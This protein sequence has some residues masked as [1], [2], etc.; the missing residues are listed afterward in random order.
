MVEHAT[1][2]DDPAARPPVSAPAQERAP[3]QLREATLIGVRWVALGRLGSEVFAFVSAVV[4]AHL[5]SPAEFGRAAVP[6]A[7]VPLAVILTFE[8]FA[9]ALVQRP[10]VKDVDRQ[11][12]V[13]LSVVSGLVLSLA[14]L[15]FA[16]TVAASV[17]SARSAHLL[18]LASPL[19]VIASVGAVPRATL[20]RKLDFR[21]VS[22]VEV[23]SIAVGASASIGLAV[24]GHDAEALIGGALIGTGASSL[25]FV[26]LVPLPTG[27]PSVHSIREIARFG[28]PASIA[29]LIGVA[30]T[31][32]SYVILAARAGA[33]QT[34]L[35][36]RAF[37]LGV[38]YQEKVSG[39]MLRVAFPVYS[40]AKDTA[41][42][43]RV[44]ERATRV[45]ATVILPMLTLLIAL[46]PLLIPWLLGSA[47]VAAVRPT[48]ILAL[49][50][51]AS[52]LLTGYPQVMLGMGRPQMLL[53]F[54]IA[55]LAVY[56]TVVSIAAGHG[57][58]TVCVCVVVVQFA[59]LWAVY[60][61]LF[62][63][64]LGVPIRRL[65]TDV[66]PAATG[67]VSLLAVAV[68]VRL[69]LDSLGLPAVVTLAVAGLLALTAYAGTV[70]GFFPVA[71]AD[72]VL[73]TRGITRRRG[74]S[75]VP[76]ERTTV[77]APAA[78]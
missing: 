22:L 52:A 44:H 70:R 72:V 45:H 28:I 37:Q 8:G 35:Y 71:W 59:V 43:R 69:V 61:F 51:M 56:I 29:G 15:L 27:R 17:F 65:L 49:A 20:W 33:F 11:S 30:V 64:L 5:L 3:G 50:G 9:A 68:P 66:L 31:S 74:S 6:L 14:A 16:R 23:I 36:W 53:R 13:F 25:L 4:L 76:D 38:S 77:S 1:H 2:L 62:R 75:G 7:L 63:R 10:E 39:I 40:R 58:L 73:L 34:G 54:N 78:T 60:R 47:W 19:F 42:L 67:S 24:V 41:E 21:R 12:A 32:A 26:V 55:M 57:L 46:A 18:E 48:Q